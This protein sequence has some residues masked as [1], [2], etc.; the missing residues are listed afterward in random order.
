MSEVAPV[1]PTILDV[2]DAPDGADCQLWGSRDDEPA[3]C[4][5]DAAFL[6]VYER[7]TDPDDDRRANALSCPGCFSPPNAVDRTGGDR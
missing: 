6:F 5:R 2:V 3:P 7:S 1:E 4:D